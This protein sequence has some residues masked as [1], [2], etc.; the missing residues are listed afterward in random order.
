MLQKTVFIHVGRDFSQHP[1]GRYRTD[2]KKSG[3][4]FR[5]NLLIP[6]LAS[7]DKVVI[8]FTGVLVSSG[9][10]EEVFG[11]LVRTGKYTHDELTAKLSIIDKR[12]SFV[13]RSAPRYISDAFAAPK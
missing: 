6:K 3:E 10:V 8:D 11:G 1:F 4:A 2:G 9:F 13:V 5:E 7:A 12:D